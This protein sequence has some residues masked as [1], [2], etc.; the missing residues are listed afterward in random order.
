MAFRRFVRALFRQHPT[1]PIKRQ[2]PPLRCEQLEERVVPV[3]NLAQE[4]LFSGFNSGYVNASVAPIDS[5]LSSAWQGAGPA[6]L[7]QG[8]GGNLLP[9]AV[10]TSGNT[11]AGGQYRLPG[12]SSAAGPSSYSLASLPTNAAWLTGLTS[13]SSAAPGPVATAFGAGW[14]T[15][16]VNPGYAATAAAGAAAYGNGTVN[17][18]QS[19]TWTS[20][21]GIT[22][23]STTNETDT[24]SSVVTGTSNTALDESGSDQGSL[25]Q[26]SI[27][28]DA[29][30]NV[31]EEISQNQTW[32]YSGTA[33]VT[34]TPDGQTSTTFTGHGDVTYS[35]TVTQNSTF[36]ILVGAV[37]DVGTS[38]E[39]DITD[40]SCTV[41]DTGSITPLTTIS[42]TSY[43]ADSTVRHDLSAQGTAT[44]SDSASG[45]TGSEQFSYTEDSRKTNH[46]SGTQNVDN[47][48]TT[49]TSAFTGLQEASSSW[50]DSGNQNLLGSLAGVNETAE[51]DNFSLQ[52][53]FSESY[54]LSGSTYD[55][56][57]TMQVQ[58]VG[59]ASRNAS[60][61]GSDT[62]Q[63]AV[64]IDG[65]AGLALGSE[66]FTTSADVSAATS[67][68]LSFEGDASTTHLDSMDQTATVNQTTQFRD[69]GTVTAEADPTGEQLGGGDAFT[70]TNTSSTTQTV[71]TQG[72]SQNLTQTF[73]AQS[74][75]QNLQ[76]DAG[77]ETFQGG[78]IGLGP[79]MQG[80]L[81]NTLGAR[82]GTS[83][84]RAIRQRRRQPP[85][86]TTTTGGRRES[87][88]PPCTRWRTRAAPA[89]LPR[90]C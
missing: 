21:D 16:W 42:Q 36:D 15:A 11:P 38:T 28:T 68:N 65:E 1:A 90:G 17:V 87:L 71:T 79:N 43:T 58:G 74:D 60:N 31:L 57:S 44:L 89:S 69:Q 30:G 73:D 66:N 88:R 18:S 45:S 12:D 14:P 37:A 78:N 70:T 50:T 53:N 54:N 72:D 48:T 10:V 59:A 46:S 6:A 3:V 23:T 67:L 49:T 8:Q 34:T 52:Q 26:V 5:G 9:S 39:T 13:N 25:Y 33:V 82:P 19:T 20:P 29:S 86:T 7:P 75:G 22:I 84:A 56:S 62:F 27:T 77:I 2:S 35:E 51:T 4:S 41:D 40:T 76:N 80:G 63:T 81:G 55:A 83:S 24:S 85:A 32:N 61:G 64:G 47:Q